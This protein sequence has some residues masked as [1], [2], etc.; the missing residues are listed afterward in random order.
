MSSRSLPAR[1]SSANCAYATSVAVNLDGVL[2][3]EFM[4]ELHADVCPKPS[5][6]IISC[7]T[8]CEL[9]SVDVDRRKTRAS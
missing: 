1:D 9:W 4:I 6:C 2:A 5:A 8:T 7:A 3:P